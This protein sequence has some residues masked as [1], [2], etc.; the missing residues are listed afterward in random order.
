M[1]SSSSLSS[2]I[3]VTRSYSV[4]TPSFSC[5]LRR[6]GEVM[7]VKNFGLE[8]NE[9]ICV[10]ETPYRVL[11][12]GVARA[13]RRPSFSAT[14]AN[15]HVGV[16]F[17]CVFSLKNGARLLTSQRERIGSTLS[18]PPGAML[19]S[20]SGVVCS[21]KLK[22]AHVQIVNYHIMYRVSEKIDK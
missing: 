6:R 14:G 21:P 13:S 4:T 9:T 11:V 7:L 15:Q 5:C 8:K 17:H 3:D 18:S 22:M 19:F 12:V 10:E 20:Q 16:G 2:G 1:L